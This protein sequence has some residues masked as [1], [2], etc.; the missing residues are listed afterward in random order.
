M[1]YVL[2]VY[3]DDHLVL[4]LLY[5]SICWYICAIYVILN[6]CIYCGNMNC[7]A[8]IKNSKK[9]SQVGGFAVCMHTAKLP[10]GAH[11]CFLGSVW[12]TK[13]HLCRA[14]LLGTRQIW[15]PLVPGRCFAVPFA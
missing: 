7:K 15:R 10:R 2:C 13:C 6:C 9:M 4:Y 14:H 1:F 8:V 12:V 11:L 5:C 3:D